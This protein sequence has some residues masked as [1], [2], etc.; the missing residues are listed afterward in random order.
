MNVFIN[1][2]TSPSLKVGRL[3]GD[4]LKGTVQLRGAATFA[5]LTITPDAVESLSPI[6]V[7]DPTDELSRFVRSWLVSPACPLPT[8]RDP[9]LADMPES[10]TW[11]SV[12]AERHGLIN[13]SRLY[14]SPTAGSAAAVAWLKT[15]V[16]SDQVQEKH[17]SLGWAREI[18]VYV[19]GKLVFS[20]R[21]FYYPAEAR[22]VPDGRLSL[23]NGSFTLPLRKGTNQVVVALSNF[24]PQGH[25]HYGWGLELRFDDLREIRI[26]ENH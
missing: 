1:A 15:T 22:K 21:N 8:G 23:E 7:E 16:D 25:N 18:W 19:N 11:R 4:A 3:E 13:L 2:E 5:N 17:V 10:N 12:T 14:G 24:F 6:P 26:P 9:V 20:G